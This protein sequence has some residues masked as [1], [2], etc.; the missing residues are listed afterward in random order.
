MM[1]TGSKLGAGWILT[2]SRSRFED[3][4]VTEVVHVID[5]VRSLEE[6][7][8]RFRSELDVINNKAS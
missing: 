3:R 8:N 4:D 7:K 1:E 5:D 2:N 6:F